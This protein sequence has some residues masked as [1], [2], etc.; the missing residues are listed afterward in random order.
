MQQARQEIEVI[1]QNELKKHKICSKS[2]VNKDLDI[3]YKRSIE[4]VCKNEGLKI[5]WDV[6]AN[7]LYL[8]GRE[9]SIFKAQTKILDIISSYHDDENNKKEAKLLSYEIQWE[10]EKLVVSSSTWYKHNIFVNNEM[11]KSYKSTDSESFEFIGDQNIVYKAEP[12]KLIQ[13][14]VD[15][16]NDKINLRR[17]KIDELKISYNLP[18]YWLA[19]QYQNL[20][21]LDP[22]EKEYKE[23]Q[24]HFNNGG[25]INHIVSI[26][27]VQ[28]KRLYI[29]YETHK[30]EF[31]KK[32]KNN[33]NEMRLFH[34]TTQSSVEKIWVNGFNRSYAGINGTAYGR[35]VY[36]ARASSYSHGYTDI[37]KLK[38]K[39]GQMFF[40]RVL[41][42][43]VEQ[44]SSSMNIPPTGADTTVENKQNPT[45]FVI[46]HDAQ[47]YPEYLITY[48]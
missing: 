28:N 17:L 4:M 30:H 35:G 10:Y 16:P 12:K 14:R 20:I 11:E 46:Y 1:A 43:N 24:L 23:I 48:E 29:Q 47:A 21:L 40:S 45:I 9:Q 18:D 6:A 22:N 8:S 3:N 2:F 42:G 32:Y 13:Y 25:L 37:N 5:I 27:R 31:Q 19:S 39:Q 38:A 34:G 33:P 26:H 36:F 15:T 44:G 7:T 41:V